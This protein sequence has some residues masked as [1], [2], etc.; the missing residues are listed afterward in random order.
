MEDRASQQA[1]AVMILQDKFSHVEFEVVCD[2]C[3]YDHPERRRDK[4][5]FVDSQQAG[6]VLRTFYYV[7]FDAFEGGPVW[8]RA[9]THVHLVWTDTIAVRNPKDNNAYHL[10]LPFPAEA[11]L[12]LESVRAD[13]LDNC[14]IEAA[15]GETVELNRIGPERSFMWPKQYVP[16]VINNKHV[17]FRALNLGGEWREAFPG[18]LLI[19][20]DEFLRCYGEKQPDDWISEFMYDMT[21][22]QKTKLILDAVCRKDLVPWECLAMLGVGPVE[23]CMDDELM[24]ALEALE[25]STADVHIRARLCETLRG[26]YVHGETDEIQKRWKAVLRKVA[27]PAVLDE[28]RTY[29]DRLAKD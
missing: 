9:R 12:T 21:Y 18:A 25:R 13:V 7:D 22:A 11:Y 17:R 23:D 29:F 15:V 4:W 2:L 14:L 8:G 28:L 27:P 20:W 16:R 26:I 10:E 6:Q 3:N 5:L 19:T 1:F 24:S